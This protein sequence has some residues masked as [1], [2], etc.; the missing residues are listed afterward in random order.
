M[1]KD[2]RPHIIIGRGQER[3]AVMQ[4][5]AAH[6]AAHPELADAVIITEEELEEK[7]ENEMGQMKN[8][9]S[10]VALLQP[11]GWD[12]NIQMFKSNYT[13]TTPAEFGASKRCTR[14]KKRNNKRKR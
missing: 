9:V 3:L 6:L 7:M 10:A 8:L 1:N 12:H 5:L 14:M 13:E 2:S 4:I 11:S